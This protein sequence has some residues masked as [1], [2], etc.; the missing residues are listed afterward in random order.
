MAKFSPGPLA[1]QISG[2]IGGSTYSHN[3]YG[4]YIRR[5]AVPV[6]ST[7]EA[8]MNAKSRLGNTSQAWQALT[9]AQKLAWKAWGDYNPTIDALGNAQP[10]AGNVAYIQL[11]TRLLQAGQSQISTPPIIPAPPSLASLVQECDIGAGDCDLTF[12]ATPLGAGLMLRIR[13]A[14]VNSGGIKYVRNLMRVVG[15]SAAAQAS[16]FDHQSLVEAVFGTLVVG[17]WVHVLVDVLDTA[18]GQVSAALKDVTQV[19]TT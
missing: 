8:A 15:F 5:R 13:A 19:T 11:N 17:Q 2:S 6:T 10:L 1:G 18:T 12:T 7:T 3:R 16:P 14:V 4:P 9:A